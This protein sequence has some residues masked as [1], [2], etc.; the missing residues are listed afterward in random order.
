MQRR[1]LLN[2]RSQR[3]IEQKATKFTEITSRQRKFVHYLC[4]LCDLLFRRFSP[5][6]SI[7]YLFP[8]FAS[9]QNLL[10]SLAD[11]LSA[12]ALATAEALAKSALYSLHS[13]SLFFSFHLCGFASLREFF[14]D[15]CAM[16][17]RVSYLPCESVVFQECTNP[18]FILL[19]RSSTKTSQFNFSS[20]RPLPRTI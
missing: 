11:D 1:G 15:L 19:T 7:H 6:L 12:I 20:E 9:V 5:L 17:Q 10:R 3:R 14:P 13:H 18:L 4:G 16:G 8:P 2:K